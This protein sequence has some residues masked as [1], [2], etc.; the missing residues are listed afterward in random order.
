MTRTIYTIILLIIF[1]SCSNNKSKKISNRLT[2]KELQEEIEK[3]SSFADVYNIV[4]KNYDTILNTD[5]LKSKY[6]DLTY[7]EVLQS[8]KKVIDTNYTDKYWTKYF[9]E[10][11][12]ISKDSLNIGV[13]DYVKPKLDSIYSKEFGKP[14]NFLIVDD[15]LNL[16][17]GPWEGK[18][19]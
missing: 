1:F 14:F 7:N 3:D 16:Y 6:Y 9:D 4:L 19:F 13:I 11:V 15:R 12:A 17:F 5:V 18:Y 10:W 8:Y 2:L